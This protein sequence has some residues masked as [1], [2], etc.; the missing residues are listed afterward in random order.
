[1]KLS[2]GFSEENISMFFSLVYII[3]KLIQKSCG[4]ES[5]KQSSSKIDFVIASTLLICEGK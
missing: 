4:I 5:R 1:M 2:L 3:S